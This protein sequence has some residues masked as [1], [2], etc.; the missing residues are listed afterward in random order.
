MFDLHT[1][2]VASGHYTTD[3][4][5]QLIAAARSKGLDALGISEHAPAMAGTCRASYFMALRTM[6]RRRMGQELLLGV[7]L[8]LLDERGTVDLP[9]EILEGLD[10]AI[11]SL[12]P[13]LF[14]YRDENYTTEAYL[15]A[16]RNP[17]VNI[18]GH[19]DD[20]KYPLQLERFLS[21]AKETGTLPEL[22]NSSLT[23][24][25]RGDTRAF[26]LE[27]L[28]L[29]KEMQVPVI[30]GSDSHGGR[31]VGDF[32]SCLELVEQVAFPR[33]LIANYDLTAFRRLVAEK[34]QRK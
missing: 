1:H 28:R 9:P 16:M 6:P 10:Y 24:G 15:A 4:L 30:L 3:T 27:F 19:P 23:S 18:I 14:P 20:Q 34:R 12:H 5:T 8:N 22:N 13:P 29:C 32:S 11:A 2:T 25:Y 17:Y 31:H 21:A 33:E 26:D 7:E